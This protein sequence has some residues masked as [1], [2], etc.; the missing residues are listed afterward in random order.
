M[1]RISDA[2]RNKRWREAK[3]GKISRETAQVWAKEARYQDFGAARLLEMKREMDGLTPIKTIQGQAA[4][5]KRLLLSDRKR[6]DLELF[7]DEAL[8]STTE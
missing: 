5:F 6:S 7:S 4:R 1:P 8:F 2:E 3:P